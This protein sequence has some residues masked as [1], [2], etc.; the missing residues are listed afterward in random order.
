MIDEELLKYM[1]ANMPKFNK[2]L[3]DGIG[4]K[5]SGEI[6]K[7]LDSRWREFNETMK[8]YDFQY[9]GTQH[10]TPE[11]R[12]NFVTKAKEGKRNCEL[13]R[14]DYYYVKVHFR[15]KGVPMIPRYLAVPFIRIHSM[16]RQYGTMYHAAPS[17]NSGMFSVEDSLIFVDITKNNLKFLKFHGYFQAN[18]EPVSVDVYHAHLHWFRKNASKTLRP[19]VINYILTQCGV[20]ECMRKYFDTDVIT[21]VDLV[22]N[23]N[24]KINEEEYYICTSH[25]VPPKGA[26]RSYEYPTLEIA[27]KKEDLTIANKSAIASIFYIVDIC[28]THGY[29]DVA[30]V[31]DPDLW[32]RCLSHFILAEVSEK[33]MWIYVGDMLNSI[34]EYIDDIVL[35][36]FRKLNLDI[37]DIFELMA[38]I[39]KTYP[40]HSIG[41]RPAENTKRKVSA[42][43]HIISAYTSYIMRF[44]YSLQRG[45]KANK[46]PT[47]LD[48]EITRM[49]WKPRFIFSAIV[50]SK[51]VETMMTVS[52]QLMFKHTNKV[53]VPSK[54]DNSGGK[55]SR[56][57]NEMQNPRFFM[58]PDMVVANSWLAITKSS[59]SAHGQLNTFIE[60]EED[61]SVKVPPD[62]DEYIAHIDKLMKGI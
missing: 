44:A 21:G 5:E 62:A 61:G 9:T 13:A 19:Q 3:V 48:K 25:G 12:L 27:I 50:R 24:G 34:R 28:Y 15:Y 22:E 49:L 58:S 4:Y 8:Q 37:K 60:L 7:V 43:K 18:G 29:F 38:Y 52:D 42:T 41:Y 17:F 46:T 35:K 33:D 47:V 55:K 14:S 51:S 39:I 32:T 10:L 23:S 6:L 26:I 1:D 2:D 59:P 20:T 40:E 45:I 16:H 11:E 54:N 31:E 56:K 36:E 30:D 57:S 53:F